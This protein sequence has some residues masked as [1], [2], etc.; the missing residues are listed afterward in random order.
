MN[1]TND[2]HQAERL[3]LEVVNERYNQ[4]AKWGRQTHSTDR[5]ISIL[6]EEVG[7]LAR[8]FNESDYR[9]AEE[10]AI[11]VAAV[12]LAILEGLVSRDDGEN[13][14]AED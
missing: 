14:T 8:A 13:D 6:V 11:Q 3:S 1:L 7:E 4:Y 2:V 10:E 9:N 5:W 12:A